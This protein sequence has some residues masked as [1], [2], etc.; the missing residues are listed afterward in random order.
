MR[1]AAPASASAAAAL[2]VA[3]STQA[4][5]KEFNATILKIV[6]VTCA[7]A[8]RRLSRKH[9]EVVIAAWLCHG[10]LELYGYVKIKN[11]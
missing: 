8:A 5:T 3:T 11:I 7:Q 6:F 4:A 2:R 9:P 1:R 10:L